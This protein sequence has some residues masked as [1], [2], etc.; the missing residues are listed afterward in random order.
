MKKVYDTPE[1]EISYVSNE[2]ILGLSTNEG[3]FNW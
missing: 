1:V 3:T 2:V